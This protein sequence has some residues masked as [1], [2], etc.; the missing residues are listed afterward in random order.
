MRSLWL[1]SAASGWN[2]GSQ[3][4]VRNAM[5]KESSE[6]AK[7]SGGESREAQR[8]NGDGVDPREVGSGG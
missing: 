3:E 1:G 4:A 2:A 8:G 7:K 6:F 5:G